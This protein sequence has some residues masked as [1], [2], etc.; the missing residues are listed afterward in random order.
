[1]SEKKLTEFTN[2]KCDKCGISPILDYD[3]CLCNLDFA[4]NEFLS[5]LGID[6]SSATFICFGVG[7][8]G[9]EYLTDENKLDLLK[10]LHETYQ[11]RLNSE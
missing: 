5:D 3:V 8:I 7:H 10:H 11:Q 1:M 4:I 9:L 2:G 6:L